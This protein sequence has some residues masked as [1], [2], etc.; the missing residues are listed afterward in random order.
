MVENMTL[1]KQGDQYVRFLEDIDM[2]QGLIYVKQF[3]IVIP[4]YEGEKDNE[5]IN[6]PWFTKFL[7]VLNAKDNVEKIIER[8]RAFLKGKKLLETRCNLISE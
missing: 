6:K 5:Q 3:Y 1:Q 2:K 4:Y 8:Y 7:N